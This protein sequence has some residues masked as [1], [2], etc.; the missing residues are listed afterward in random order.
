[1]TRAQ[2]ASKI[3]NYRYITQNAYTSLE[4]F[5]DTIIEDNDWNGIVDVECDI[6]ID[7]VLNNLSQ[8]ERLLSESLST[9]DDFE[10]DDDFSLWP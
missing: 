10:W 4:K 1:M 3:Q 2:A 7:T 5:R 9:L 8:A 6:A